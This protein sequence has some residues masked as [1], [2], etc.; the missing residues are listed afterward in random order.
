[1]PS[2]QPPPIPFIG[3]CKFGSIQTRAP[4]WGSHGVNG[5]AITVELLITAETDFDYVRLVYLNCDTATHVITSAAIAA[6]GSV[7]D[8]V[9]PTNAAGTADTT[10]WNLVYFN[11]GG[12]AGNVPS[13]A[14]TTR[15]VTCAAGVKGTG[16]SD[17]EPS[18]T[19]SDW[20]Q[21]SSLART[22]GGTLP[23]LMVRTYAATSID[24]FG[25]NATV[26][27]T[28][29]GASAGGSGWDTYANGRIIRTYSNTTDQATSPTT[30]TAGAN[31]LMVPWGVQTISRK[32]GLSIGLFGDSLYQGFGTLSLQND[33]WQI[34]MAALSTPA[35]PIT[36]A[37]FA[38]T[39]MTT[40]PFQINA[41][42]GM[43][44]ILPDVAFYKPESPN[45][46]PTAALFN[47]SF[48]RAL[49]FNDW[50]TRQGVV[51]VLCTAMPWSYTGTQ[52]AARVAFNAEVRASN[53][54]YMDW[55]ALMT[56][57]ANPGRIQSGYASTASPLHYNDAGAAVLAA[58]AVQP[59]L[60]HIMAARP[61]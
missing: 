25:G 56:N 3:P 8:G 44:G 2:S 14:G 38:Y 41:Y 1:M 35:F 22:D 36:I 11:N 48:A 19:Y 39:G 21:V 9:N 20:I 6:S 47:G 17:F 32:R 52:E 59:I 60:Q 7:N 28:L 13:P 23:L 18:I 49:A 26:L 29:N 57:G 55:D 51:P 42:A 4:F 31:S 15:T 40:P 37:K 61:R 27:G 43:P 24:T 45:D 34:A 50:C 33:P 46:N 54:L 58:Q 30:A 53:Y 16:T 10:L 12:A 5:S